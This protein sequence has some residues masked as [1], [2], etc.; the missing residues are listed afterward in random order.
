MRCARLELLSQLRLHLAREHALV[1]GPRGLVVAAHHRQ[2]VGP[3]RRVLQ[4]RLEDLGFAVE[5]LDPLLDAGD[6][7][8]HPRPLATF[9]LQPPLR[10]LEPR[11]DVGQL[12]G[13]FLHLRVIRRPLRLGGDQRPLRLQLLRLEPAGLAVSGI[14]G[15]EHVRPTDLGRAEI[16]GAR[17]NGR[18]HPLQPAHVELHLLG[19]LAEVVDLELGEL[20]LPIGHRLLQRPHLVLEKTSGPRRHR[21]PVLHPFLGEDLRQ[22]IGHLRGDVRILPGVGELE[23]RVALQLHRDV[24]AHPLDRRVHPVLVDDLPVQAHLLDGALEHGPRHQLLADRHHPSLRHL[25]DGRLHHLGDRMMRLQPD[26]NRGLV[27]VGHRRH[28]PRAHQKRQSGDGEH[29]E[30]APPQRLDHLI[31]GHPTLHV[32]LLSPI[33]VQLTRR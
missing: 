27:G 18:G 8:R 4:P 11:A 26:G 24:L 16:V 19:E 23:R 21:L 9:F 25:A 28:D 32:A 10:V 31:H 13:Q 12:P 7:L 33:P 1:L 15:A 3:L 29:E 20:S 6:Q 22:P 2:L 5:A 30:F 14:V 17:A